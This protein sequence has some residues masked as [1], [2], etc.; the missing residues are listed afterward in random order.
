MV[1]WTSPLM[2]DYVNFTT[3][4][5]VDMTRFFAL[6][7]NGR[8]LGRYSCMFM[9]CI[10]VFIHAKGRMW[11][12]F[13][14]EF[15]LFEL[16]LLV[17]WLVWIVRW[18]PPSEKRRARRLTSENYLQFL[19]CPGLRFTSNKFPLVLYVQTVLTSWLYLPIIPVSKTGSRQYRFHLIYS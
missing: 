6:E 3:G 9:R 8:R 16:L 17:Y 10:H 11:K 18:Y 19:K 1:N 14:Y 13:M 4:E 7:C 2:F 15:E 5:N 12:P